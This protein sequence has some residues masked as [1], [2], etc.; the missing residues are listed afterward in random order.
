[1]A[2]LSK[3]LLRKE[4]HAQVHIKYL[5]R[6]LGLGQKCLR[7]LAR[8]WVS[9]AHAAKTH[10]I[11]CVSQLIL[12]AAKLQMIPGGINH[13]LITGGTLFKT[14]EHLASWLEDINL[15]KLQR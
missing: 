6:I 11:T 12:M 15:Y 13:N 2:A 7:S 10:R 1:M 14:H 8:H 5:Q 9:L 4:I 3:N